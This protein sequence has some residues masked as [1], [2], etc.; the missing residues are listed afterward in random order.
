MIVEDLMK[1]P[2]VIDKDI[3]L[4]EAAKIMSSKGIGSLLF[5]SG[6]EIKGIITERDL[7]KN[8]NKNVQVKKVMVKD[9]RTIESNRGI[10]EALGVMR[11]NGIKRL[12]VVENKKVVGIITLIDIAIHLDEIDEEFFFN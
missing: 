7:L 3:S 4:R 6:N 2:Y 1:H 11:E 9:V 10:E 8:F 5:I 12:P